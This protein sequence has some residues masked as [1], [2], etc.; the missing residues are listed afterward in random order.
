AHAYLATVVADDDDRPE[1]EA[2]PALDDL[3]NA[4]D[5]EYALVKLV[6]FLHAGFTSSHVSLQLH[7]LL[8]GE[9]R[10]DLEIQP[11]FTRGIGQSLHAAMILV[12][13]PVEY[14]LLHTRLLGTLCDELA[15]ELGGVSLGLAVNISPEIG[16]DGRRGSQRVAGGVVDHLSVD[17]L[18]AAENVQTRPLSRPLDVLA[19]A[20]MPPR[21]PFRT[22][23]C[24]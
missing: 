11:R 6:T 3:G 1:G 9:A 22:I 12:A 8:A 20:V 10:R 24:L 19:H 16:I 21:A 23:P 2:T 13:A 17:V 7:C 5:V 4:R 18:V 15:D 14:N